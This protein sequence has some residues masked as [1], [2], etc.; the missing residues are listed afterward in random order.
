[1]RSSSR[2]AIAVWVAVAVPGVAAAAPRIALGSVQRDRNSLVR[3]QLT[4]ALCGPFEC[5]KSSKVV[6]SGQ[7]DFTKMRKQNVAGFLYGSVSTKKDRKT[8]SLKLL[9]RTSRPTKTWTQPLDP[10]G[11]LPEGALGIIQTDLEAILGVAPRAVP[12]PPPPVFATPLPGT[13]A[14]AP[15][16]AVGAGAA[17]GA[18]AEAGT[19][20]AGVPA[21]AA[22]LAVAPE[23]PP[24]PAATVAPPPPPPG[25]PAAKPAAAAEERLKLLGVQA[26]FGAPDGAVL[27]AIYRP[28]YWLRLNGGLA[29]NYLSFGLQAGA[30]LIPFHFGITPTLTGEVGY[31]FPGNLNARLSRWDPDI[32]PE[33]K[34]LLD[35]VGYTYLSTQ[36]GLEFGGPDTFVFFIRGGLAWFFSTTMGPTSGTSGTT[37][38]TV[39]GVSIRSAVPTVNLGFVVY[40]W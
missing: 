13:P 16:L 28:W 4:A 2:W 32:P 27:S 9:T 19:A 14:P 22:P 29:W 36:F 1:M 6:T 3:G 15:A 35:S 31:F 33:L 25:A 18:A 12:P 23:P 34:P 11:I 7:L 24:L 20:A 17:A 37:S 5:V 8:L 39:D 10:P 40:I 21:A 26:A 38:Y 30:T